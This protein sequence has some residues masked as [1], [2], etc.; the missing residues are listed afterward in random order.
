MVIYITVK[1]D[2]KL[3]STD[4]SRYIT[5]GQTQEIDFQK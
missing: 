3:K 2:C 4:R 5:M 1:K